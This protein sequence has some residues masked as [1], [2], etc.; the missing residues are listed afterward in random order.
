MTDKNTT[1][2]ISDLH[3]DP[4][5]PKIIDIFF[6][7]LEH[8]AIHADALYILGDFFEAYIG[9]DDTNPFITA[10]QKALS[11][12]VD[13]GL[14]IFLMHG[15]RDFMIGP[16]F[17]LQSGITLMP[18]PYAI[19]LYRQKIVL[20]HGDSLCTK[21]KNYQLFRKIIQN[22]LLKKITLRTPL[23]FRQ[24]LAYKLR[25]ESTQHSQ[26]KSAEKMDV[27]P[28][29]VSQLLSTYDADILIH[30]HTHNPAIH[31]LSDGKKRIVLSAWHENG[32]YLEIKADQVP[33]LVT[34]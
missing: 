20:S 6:Y 2:F 24:K 10:V 18:D 31:E 19:T 34:L 16:S 8:I 1:L 23:S 15:N 14:S 5:N 32:H 7:F 9:D 11:K 12:A 33:R 27:T 29:A 13:K 30:G 25:K 22:T 4:K 21:D 28:L 26:Y 3:L 17:A